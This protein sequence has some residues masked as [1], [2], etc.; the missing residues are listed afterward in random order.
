M[1]DRWVVKLMKFF[2]PSRIQISVRLFTLPQKYHEHIF[3]PKLT[4]VRGITCDFTISKSFL[5]GGNCIRSQ[6]NMPKFKINGI[7]KCTTKNMLQVQVLLQINGFNIEK[8]NENKFLC[9]IIDDKICSKS[10][11]KHIQTKLSRSI[12]V[13]TKVKHILNCKSFHILYCSLGFTM[14]KLLFKGL[15]RRLIC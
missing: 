3:S 9:V 14:F 13:L 8:V 2:T 6:I 1:M 5:G 10:H 11:I 4:G 12:S 7:W 15:W